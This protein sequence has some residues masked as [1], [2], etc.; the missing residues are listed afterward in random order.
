LLASYPLFLSSFFPLFLS[1]QATIAALVEAVYLQRK[2][3]VPTT[4]NKPNNSNNNTNFNNLTPS[5]KTPTN[6]LLSSQKSPTNLNINTNTNA[7]SSALKSPNFVSNNNPLLTPTMNG[8]LSFC[9]WP[10]SPLVF[11]VSSFAL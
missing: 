2:D 9:T 8:M 3:A 6:S 10:L 1:L 11:A 7:N 4:P 5:N